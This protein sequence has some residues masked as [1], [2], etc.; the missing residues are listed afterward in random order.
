MTCIYQIDSKKY[1]GD[2]EPTILFDE[3]LTSMVVLSVNSIIE[4]FVGLFELL[5]I[6]KIMAEINW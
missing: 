4:L 3:F 2:A 6:K 5:I 1:S